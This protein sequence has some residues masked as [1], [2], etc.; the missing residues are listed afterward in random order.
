MS[1]CALLCPGAALG[2]QRFAAGIAD[3]TGAPFVAAG[4]AATGSF[5]GYG[6][7][8]G[9]NAAGPQQPLPRPAA[10]GGLVATAVPPLKPDG[11]CAPIVVRG[12]WRPC[13]AP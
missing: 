7:S 13:D 2:C 8:S 6:L 1:V 11:S 3:A 12:A 4:L 10:K 5:A 9:E